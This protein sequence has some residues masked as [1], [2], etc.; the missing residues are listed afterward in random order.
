MTIKPN[1]HVRVRDL[2]DG[3]TVFSRA[4][5]FMAPRDVNVPGLGK[6]AYVSVI[7]DD[8]RPVLV[9]ESCCEVVL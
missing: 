7:A 2:R 4:R 8:G 9:P 6:R 5:V 1:D 3:Q